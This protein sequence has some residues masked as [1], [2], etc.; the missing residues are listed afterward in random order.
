VRGVWPG[1]VL[2]APSGA[3]G[4]GY[5]PVFRP[6]GIETSSAELTPDEKNAIS[7]RARAFGL[8]LDELRG[9]YG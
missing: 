7:H 5:D 6:E 3:H 9:L 1:E 2:A 4:F 8:L